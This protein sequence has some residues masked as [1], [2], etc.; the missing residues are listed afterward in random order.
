[1]APIVAEAAGSIGVDIDM[2]SRGLAAED[3]G[4]AR[5]AHCAQADHCVREL[6]VAPAVV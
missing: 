2:G 3:E 1:M 4:R 6:L 5:K